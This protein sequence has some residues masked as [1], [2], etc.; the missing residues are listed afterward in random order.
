MFKMRIFLAV[1]ARYFI[2]TDRHLLRVSG[3]EAF[4]VTTFKVLLLSLHNPHRNY[5]KI[6]LWNST[7]EAV[8]YS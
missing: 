5:F 6:Y 2:G 4:D 8:L 1:F 3:I 7:G